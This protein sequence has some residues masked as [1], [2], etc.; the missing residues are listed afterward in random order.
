[1]S[2]WTH[3]LGVIRFDSLSKN[4]YPKLENEEEILSFQTEYLR[5]L[6]IPPIFGKE[7]TIEH[8]VVMSHRGPC[9]LLTGDLCNFDEDDCD[10]IRDWLNY[11]NDKFSL[12][13]SNSD[14]DYFLEIRDATIRCEVE[15]KDTI[16]IEY[17]DG[18]FISWN[19]A[20]R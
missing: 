14:M 6:F 17:E 12:T 8:Q 10:K 2:Q 1:M 15:S 18:V 16:Y 3:V 20:S 7:R 13:Y 9:V 4:I 11:I 19:Y 5:I